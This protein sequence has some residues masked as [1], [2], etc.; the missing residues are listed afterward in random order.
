MGADADGGAVVASVAPR[1]AASTGSADADADGDDPLAAERLEKLLRRDIPD[2]KAGL[3]RAEDDGILSEGTWEIV[4]TTTTDLE[5]N[6]LFSG[7]PIVDEYGKPYVYRIRLEKPGEAE[8]V[9]LNAGKDDNLDNDVAHL[10][11]RGEEAPENMAVTETLPVISARGY[12]DAY[13]LAYHT[14][15][16]YGWTRAG[17]HAIDPGYYVDPDPLPETDGWITRIFN[18]WL[19]K[20]IRVLLPQTGDPTSLVRLVL[21]AVAGFAAM[22]LILSLL[23]RREE[24]EEA[25]RWVDI[26]I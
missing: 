25:K 18:D 1:A 11:L 17:G 4:A 15:G 9:P 13:G 16:A 21:A 8:F 14:A 6:Y 7:A 19:T 24:E 20:I 22:M 3:P 2:P 12:A 10:N 26:T 23:R 5:G